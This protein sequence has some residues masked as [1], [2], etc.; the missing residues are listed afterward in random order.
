[1]HVRGSFRSAVTARPA[2]GLTTAALLLTVLTACTAGP[3]SPD[4]TAEALAAGIAARDLSGV[5]LAATPADV[6]EGQIT[7]AL[8]GLD[9]LRPAVEVGEI[10]VDEEEGTT[11]TA[12]LEYTWDVD[13]G[14]TDW[15]YSTTAHLD[16]VEDEWQAQWSTRLLAPDLREDETLITRRTPAQR[17]NVL[18]AG[19]AVLVEPRPVL[20]LG[21]DKTRIAPE[22]H[23]VAAR[24][25]AA[26]LGI[27]PEP[28]AA[29]VAAGGEKAFV[30]G[31]V[32]RAEAPPVDL[33]ALTS[34]AGAISVP[35]TLPLAPSRRFARPVLGTAGPATAEIVEGS[36]GA[37]AAGD[38]TGLSGLQR[39][40]D[41]QLRGRPG[42]TVLA[43]ATATDPPVDRLL[44]EIGPVAGEPLVTTLDPAWQDAA[45]MVLE[46]VVPASAIVVLRA[47]TGEVVAAAAGPGSEGYPTGTVGSYPPGSVFKVVSSLALL[48]AGL[49]PQSTVECPPTATVDGRT[50]SNFPDYPA[51]RTGPI[52]LGTAVAFSCNTAF[53]GARDQ[54]PAAS[55]IEAGASLGVGQDADLGFPAFLGSIPADSTGTDHAASLIGQGRIEASPL[56]M[57]TVA[58]SVAAGR[59]VVPWLVGTEAPSA[60]APAVPLTAAEAEALRGLLRGVVTDGGATFLADAPGG[61]VLA[62]TGTAQYASGEELRNHA[63]MIAAQGDF[64]FAVLVADGEY[65]STTA[66]PLLERLLTLMA[67]TA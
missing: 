8:A 53:I 6:A 35:D 30:E 29:A 27:D 22:A 48:R 37:I 14:E 57:A 39:Q 58:A 40:Y 26:V 31:L 42:L 24:D 47:S 49:T 43:T 32:V 67:P 1:M 23:D 62:K 45:E 11:A 13:A 4:A 54:A 55:L 59:T 60:P 52:T 63:W 50:F 44:F 33:T 15:T 65:G 5:N 3:P 2:A 61:E 36:D 56:A 66:G 18:G 25:I 64:A 21:L 10:V 17:A 16:L 38:M 19:G 41:E 12:V 28:F 51:E 20:R 34:I 9:P 46:P 7:T